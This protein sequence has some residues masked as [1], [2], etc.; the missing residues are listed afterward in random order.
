MWPSEEKLNVLYR[1]GLLH[2]ECD[3]NF[4]QIG[5]S[6]WLVAAVYMLSNT[7]FDDILTDE[8]KKIIIGMV[9]NI[10]DGKCPVI[11]AVLKK[12]G[13]NY[14]VHKLGR[15]IELDKTLQDTIESIGSAVNPSSAADHIIGYAEIDMPQREGGKGKFT[16]RMNGNT[17]I[18]TL[19]LEEEKQ[20]ADQKIQT[21][22]E[23]TQTSYEQPLRK[24]INDDDDPYPI[25]GTKFFLNLQTSLEH[26]P[27]SIPATVG[28]YVYSDT[29]A[30]MW[31][32][33]TQARELSDSFHSR[34]FIN[35]VL[36]A[37]GFEKV[38]LDRTFDQTFELELCSPRNNQVTPGTFFDSFPPPD[39][40]NNYTNL[41]AETPDQFNTALNKYYS[42][43]KKSLSTFPFDSYIQFGKQYLARTLP[44][45]D[46]L[47]NCDFF[48]HDYSDGIRVLQT[49]INQMT[50]PHF[51]GGIVKTVS[52]NTRPII[53]HAMTLRWCSTQLK[54]CDS[55]SDTNFCMSLEEDTESGTLGFNKYLD[56]HRASWRSSI[57]FF[58]LDDKTPKQIWNIFRPANVWYRDHYPRR[59]EN[60]I[61]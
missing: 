46:I 61:S 32:D 18:I 60:G 59:H 57:L 47:L 40:E 45:G 53:A 20:R 13:V 8:V 33:S 29:S 34:P 14:R 16:A 19:S 48:P 41:S 21:A 52:R 12:Y 37:S 36:K 35:A 43:E 50:F 30:T 44:P 15:R 17:P 9:K 42:N 1:S 10:D 38:K 49:L 25:Q 26:P 56:S 2:R 11:P 27:H 58:R 55:E 39:K 4:H 3:R 22:P 6:C 24:I 23:I 7:C 28:T 54:V 51:L 5:G 31:M